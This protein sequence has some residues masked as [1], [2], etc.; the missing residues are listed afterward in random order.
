MKFRIDLTGNYDRPCD[1]AVQETYD[2]RDERSVADP[3]EV[4]YYKGQSAWWYAEG[5]NHRVEGGHIVRDMPDQGWF[6]ELDTLE[7]LLDHLRLYGWYLHQDDHR[8]GQWV[9]NDHR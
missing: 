9:L 4:P 2:R 7:A 8:S 1:R 3:K 5:S 6:L